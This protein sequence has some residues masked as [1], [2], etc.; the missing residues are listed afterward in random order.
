MC[1]NRGPRYYRRTEPLWQKCQL[2]SWTFSK[3]NHKIEYVD[4]DNRMKNHLMENPQK[5]TVCE[6]I[7]FELMLWFILA[8]ADFR[9]GY[10]IWPKIVKF[11]HFPVL[12]RIRAC[13][14]KIIFTK[15][16]DMTFGHL[17]YFIQLSWNALHLRVTMQNV[18]PTWIIRYV[19]RPKI[20]AHKYKTV[21]KLEWLCRVLRFT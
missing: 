8:L 13:H 9:P 1:Y 10:V 16:V 18:D 4:I 17:W 7:E 6:E 12:P 14:I 21:N 3:L 20:L 15:N 5:Q 2:F 19:T 11:A